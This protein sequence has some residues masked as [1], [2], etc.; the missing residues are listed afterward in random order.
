M[1]MGSRPVTIR[2]PIDAEWLRAQCGGDGDLQGDVLALFISQ[3]ERLRARIHVDAAATM[4]GDLH[5]LRGAA[6]AV[7]AGAAAS[8]A[9]ALEV[10]IGGGGD[11]AAARHGLDEALTVACR[12]AA[13]LVSPQTSIG[14]AKPKE[15]R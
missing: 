14:L 11:V 10:A 2:A 1:G 4:S 9:E 6:L 5:R 15:S 3:A 7:G 13:S 12:Y 8:A